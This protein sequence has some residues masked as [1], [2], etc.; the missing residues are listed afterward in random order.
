MLENFIA[1]K[2]EK[3]RVPNVEIVIEPL[4]AANT[5]FNTNAYDYTLLLA[6]EIPTGPDEE[7]QPM[8]LFGAPLME[9][10]YPTIPGSYDTQYKFLRRYAGVFA[11]VQAA[12]AAWSGFGIKSSSP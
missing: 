12:V 9:F 7:S 11:P 4:L 8:L 1:G 10:V 6:P 3:G 5:V 2:M